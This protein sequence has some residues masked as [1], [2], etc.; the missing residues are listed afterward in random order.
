MIDNVI[1]KAIQEPKLEANIIE[2]I[3]WKSLIEM[4]I[5]LKFYMNSIKFYLIKL[6]K[7]ILNKSVIILVYLK[8]KI[9]IRIYDNLFM[10]INLIF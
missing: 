5:N 6:I 9:C 3:A 7:K 8:F 2:G 4:I 10:K 1:H